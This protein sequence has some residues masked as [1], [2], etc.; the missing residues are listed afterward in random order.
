MA[1][2][3]TGSLA[4][5]SKQEELF[6]RY[7]Q[8]DAAATRVLFSELLRVI[9]GFYRARIGSSIQGGD[10]VDD[11]AQATLLKIHLARDRYDPKLSLKT[12][13]FTI[14]SRSLIDHWRGV[15]HEKDVFEEHAEGESDAESGAQF[16]FAA[17]DLID[18]ERKTELHRDL[19]EAL[20]KLKPTER[21]I[22]YLYGVE[23]LSMAEIGSVLSISEGAA[24]LRAYRAY[25]EIR[26]LLVVW[27]LLNW[28][29][30]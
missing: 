20:K 15:A 11:L 2:K 10:D 3:P 1:K 30:Y 17:S 14:A 16:E 19:N 29:R 22:V 23:G 21:S 27:V 8:G 26:K 18:P 4:D 28:L 25:Q 7:L 9:H 13:V 24:K 6:A 12:W 5:W